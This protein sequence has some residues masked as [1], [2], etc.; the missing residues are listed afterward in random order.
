MADCTECA[1]LT[2]RD[3]SSS[4]RVFRTA[5]SANSAA[6]KKPLNAIRIGKPARPTSIHQNSPL[7]SS[8]NNNTSDSC[9]ERVSGHCSD[10]SSELWQCSTRGEC[11]KIL[12][13]CIQSNGTAPA[14]KQFPYL[15]PVLAICLQATL[16]SAQEKTPT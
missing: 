10:R 8:A 4:M 11:V 9:E 13:H 15:L 6:T 7:P 12:V 14:M 1:P 3:T 2:P 5:T 16:A